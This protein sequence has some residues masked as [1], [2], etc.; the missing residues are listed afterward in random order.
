MK[1]V[2]FV[3]IMFLFIGL[4]S[5]VND[6]TTGPHIEISDIY[7]SDQDTVLYPTLGEEF[8]FDPSDRISQTDPSYPLTYQWRYGKITIDTKGNYIVHPQDSLKMLSNEKILKF[9]FDRQ[10][11]YFLRLRVSN[12]FGSSYRYFIVRPSCKFDEG[13]VMLSR[14]ETGDAMFS[15]LNTLTDEEELVRKEASDFWYRT[16][17]EEPVLKNDIVDFAFIAGGGD[18][19]VPR[20]GYPYI[21]SRANKQ[22][23]YM[24]HA[25][26]R[27]ITNFDFSGTPLK[28]VP[29]GSRW[30]D[31]FA[32][33]D[34]GDVRVQTWNWNLEVER[35]FYKEVESWDRF[36]RVK[37]RSGG[38]KHWTFKYIL[39]LHDD[40]NSKLY[41]LAGN[42]L[43]PGAIDPRAYPGEKVIYAIPCETS[44]LGVYELYIVTQNIEKPSRITVKKIPDV[45]FTALQYLYLN[46]YNE[47]F[48]YT[49]DL[50]EGE[51]LTLKS[52]SHVLNVYQHRSILY[53]TDRKVYMWKPGASIEPKLPLENSDLCFDV[54][55]VNPNAEITCIAQDITNKY[56]FVG[57]Y[58]PNAQNERKG[59]V[60]VLDSFDLTLVKK[61]DNVAYKPM[62][63]YYKIHL[64]RDKF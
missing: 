32:Y 58:D 4:G 14:D 55:S 22:A 59:S 18:N 56:V 31:L 20:Q 33:C 54:Q 29:S 41:G 30:F 6:K 48:S 53:N 7:I 24:D 51:E 47:N 10:D 25:T 50:P 1:R 57:V 34:D 36:Q 39:F 15:V 63:I 11:P 21:L 38:E 28:L 8:V 12:E 3:V 19:S 64:L 26:L 17:D 2:I 37:I 16:S 61:W 49:Y 5:C 35:T 62:D 27:L 42:M 40:A 44:L 9:T 45:K 43:E 52:E 46:L 23:Y 13:I 60:Y